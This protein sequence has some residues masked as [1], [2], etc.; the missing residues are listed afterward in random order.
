MKSDGPCFRLVPYWMSIS[1]VK[2]PSDAD[3]ARPDSHSDAFA[4]D[5]FSLHFKESTYL[6][7]SLS[8]LSQLVNLAFKISSIIYHPF[9]SISKPTQKSKDRPRCVIK[10]TGSPKTTKN[11][12]NTALHKTRKKM[13]IPLA[14]Q[15]RLSRLLAGI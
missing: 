14:F 4:R 8:Y 6:S 9:R 3:E 2:N 12:A 5:H 10:R 11:P 15:N 13:T 1:L 7:L